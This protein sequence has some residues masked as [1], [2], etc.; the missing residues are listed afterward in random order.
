MFLQIIQL[1]SYSNNQAPPQTHP[2][3]F[4]LVHPMITGPL[5]SDHHAL[6]CNCFSLFSCKCIPLETQEQCFHWWQ[7]NTPQRQW[8]ACVYVSVC[9]AVH[10]HAAWTDAPTASYQALAAFVPAVKARHS[11]KSLQI[12]LTERSS[13]VICSWSWL[14]LLY[15]VG[16]YHQAFISFL[17]LLPFLFCRITYST[18]YYTIYFIFAPQILCLNRKI[19]FLLP[20]EKSLI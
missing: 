12:A 20:W 19:V 3:T 9:R 8:Y 16:I 1:L 10:C 5:L 7:L 4:S 15:N 6:W 13:R 2:V 18:I 17:L 11:Q 14:D